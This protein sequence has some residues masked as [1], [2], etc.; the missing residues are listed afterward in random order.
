MKKTGKKATWIKL[1]LSKQDVHL[2]PLGYR[3]IANAVYKALL[4]TLR[5][6]QN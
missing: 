4:E 1:G 5:L 3:T 6:K 2:T